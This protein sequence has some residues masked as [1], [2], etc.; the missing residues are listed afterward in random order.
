LTDGTV[1]LL[2]DPASARRVQLIEVNV[3][4]VDGRINSHWDRHQSKRD[5]RGFE[6][7]AHGA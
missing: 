6:F 1:P 4:L 5:V 2:F 7:P 3:L